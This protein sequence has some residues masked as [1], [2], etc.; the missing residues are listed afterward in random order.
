[1]RV[2]QV[3]ATELGPANPTPAKER[4][5][6]SYGHDEFALLA[7][8]LKSDL[9]K[10]G[11]EVWFD[12]DRI[13]PGGDWE[14]YI[15]EGLEWVSEFQGKGHVVLFITPHSVRR[16]DG[17]CLNELARALER[18]I[19]I[20][21][22]MVNWCEPPLSI[23]RIQWLDMQDC[24]PMEGREDR[25]LNRLEQLV[26]CLEQDHLDFGGVQA[27][28]RQRLEPLYFNADIQRH[29][30]RF[31]GRQWVFE[32]I[33]HWLADT[34]G[35]R[36]FWITGKPGA[37]KSAIA[38][39]L[40]AHRREVAAFHLCQFG[41]AL[42]SD[43][44]HAVLSIAYQLTTQ[45]PDYQSRVNS[46]NLDEI[47]AE[48]NART[49]FDNLLVQ[50]LASTPPP[51]R[52]V[53]VVIDGLDEATQNG[54]N[55]LALLLASEF[56]KTPDWLRLIIT[57]RPDPEVT[58]PLQ[59]I[60]PYE[61]NTSEEKN[62]EDL[63]TYIS[64]EFQLFHSGELPGKTVDV[65]LDKCEGL[66]L[67]VDWVRDEL[68]NKRLSLD[69]IAEFPQ[70]L[71][72]VYLQ[73]FRRSFP[74]TESYRRTFRPVLEAITAAYEPL[75][76]VFL[77][78]L[79]QWSDYDEQLILDA[80]ASLF[81]V[82]QGRVQPFHRSVLDWLMNRSTAGNF[83]VSTASGQKL[84]HEF[85]WR[86]YE[87]GIAQM[88]TYSIKHL[89]IHLATAGRMEELRQLLF[90]FKWLQAKLMISD[91]TTLS[92]DFD[93][94][95]GDQAALLVQGAIRL[96]SQVLNDD[97]TQLAG[98]MV[99]RLR[100][101]PQADIN[102]LLGSVAQGP[103]VP[104]LCPQTNSLAAAGGPL[105]RTFSANVGPVQ[106]AAFSAD[107]RVAVSLCG[108]ELSKRFTAVVWDLQGSGQFWTLKTHNS[109][110]TACAITPDGSCAIFA[111]E[112]HGLLVWNLRT[113]EQMS[114]IRGHEQPI[115]A[116]AIT[117]DGRRAISGSSDH[118]VRFWDLTAGHEI[119]R[120]EEHS[121]S[122]HAV[123]VTP[124]G[125]RA[126]SG[127][128]DCSA[129]IWDLEKGELLKTL[130]HEDR[131]WR[132]ALSDD[133]RLALTSCFWPASTI[134]LWELQS[135][136]HPVI[137]FGHSE[138]VTAL[139]FTSDCKKAVSAS[140]DKTLIVWDLA[141]GATSRVLVGHSEAVTS[142]GVTDDGRQALSGSDDGTLR[143]WDLAESTIQQVQEACMPVTAVALSADGRR[144]ISGA[145]DGGVTAWDIEGGVSL[146]EFEN[147]HRSSVEALAISNSG[148]FALSC[149]FIDPKALLWDLEEGKL[150]AE[151]DAPTAPWVVAF[152][153][154]GRV[155]LVESMHRN[156]KAWDISGG[157]WLHVS[158]T[159]VAVVSAVTW[160]PRHEK[161]VGGDRW[162]SA[163]A[164]WDGTYRADN[165]HVP[166]SETDWPPE[167]TVTPDATR[168]LAVLPSGALE[169][170]DTQSNSLLHTLRCPEYLGRLTA[171]ALS[172][173]GRLAVCSWNDSIY[174]W[175]L[176]D[177]KLAHK[178][179]GHRG[180]VNAVVVTPDSRLAISASADQSCRVWDLHAGKTV[181]TF[182]G[183][184]EITVVG[185]ASN[186][187][188]IAG[189]W[190]GAVHILRLRE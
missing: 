137:L 98:Q 128:G 36:I 32:A 101:F 150:L 78:L 90:D 139:R 170:W 179:A 110:G 151:L 64:R 62:T 117:S 24:W 158:D 8:R 168:A 53:L 142:L 66:F 31:T 169:L 7:E 171:A 5:F 10:R 73:F 129:R 166:I 189:A 45:L 126:I 114:E 2:Q 91:P 38:A 25:Y 141:T 138:Y 134:S 75:E 107:G 102:G 34:E 65:L 18:N 6:F 186:Q 89:P 50:P 77:R 76:T 15:T 61:I 22:V 143:L 83:F 113:R 52:S 28:L 184:A 106:A 33:E 108:E 9:L 123:A 118:S 1:V 163:S 140:D 190:N 96:S 11:Y 86:E 84:L 29:L 181:A 111:S 125:R 72:G 109:F 177:G 47:V 58:G 51:G 104:W 92:A 147:G 121:E 159:R 105:L 174:V 182:S 122:V 133:G 183:E 46:L 3:Q 165:W 41:H 99:G 131:V 127:S 152:D 55:E 157:A 136:R 4:L 172:P 27:R 154:E 100:G 19:T 30:K 176:G 56:S 17:Y 144:A 148:K 16:P 74:D 180:R 145:A 97:A 82:T 59:G 175:E 93:L 70:G 87:R 60:E 67:Y 69:R 167:V 63:R 39:W 135:D 49:I 88:S 43:P 130:K 44:R 37:G 162:R 103:G 149:C 42:K 112:D 124:D 178:L 115:T 120:F 81:P 160:V 146:P 132:V 173:D 153:P 14:A 57:S 185:A 119:W 94:L 21:P 164:Q 12:V 13:R 156:A 54:V 79:F 20:I 85:G 71:G 161:L 116:L 23:C 35:S 40:C 80:F 95:E 68:A 155:A 26:A 48:S 188:F 187:V